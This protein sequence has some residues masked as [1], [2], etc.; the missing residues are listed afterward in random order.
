MKRSTFITLLLLTILSSCST[1]VKSKTE[2]SNFEIIISKLDTT[3]TLLCKIVGHSLDS[4]LWIK[5]YKVEYDD[6]KVFVIIEKSLKS[7]GISDPFFFEFVIPDS[8]EYV[9]LG[10]KEVIWSR[11]N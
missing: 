3:E 8:A 2:I 11:P 9:Y 10:K 5:S 1:I 6:N 7:T 4:A